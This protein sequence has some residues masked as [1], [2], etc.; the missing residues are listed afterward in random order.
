[1]NKRINELANECYYF[2]TCTDLEMFDEEQFANLIVQECLSNMEDC[3]GDLDFAIWKT[4]KDL[5]LKNERVITDAERF[6]FL[7]DCSDGD[8]LDILGEQ[9]GDRDGLTKMVDDLIKESQGD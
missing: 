7:C 9:L 2:D 1:M 3:A 6:N 4:K 5:V 8:A